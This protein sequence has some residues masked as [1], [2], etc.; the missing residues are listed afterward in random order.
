MKPCSHGQASPLACMDCLEE[1]NVPAR[2]DDIIIC[3]RRSDVFASNQLDPEVV[4]ISRPFKAKYA[5][6]CMVC[7]DDWK[8]GDLI[9]KLSN[10]RYIDYFPCSEDLDFEER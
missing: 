8:I 6:E 10:N 7:G 1:G 5:G 2:R 3:A 9:V 4:V